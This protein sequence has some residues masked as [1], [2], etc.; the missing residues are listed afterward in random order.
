MIPFRPIHT[1]LS[2]QMKN[3]GRQIILY[4]LRHLS[5]LLKKNLKWILG[6]SEVLEFRTLYYH[7]HSFLYPLYR[8]TQFIQCVSYHHYNYVKYWTH[9]NRTQKVTFLEFYPNPYKK[10]PYP[11]LFSFNEGRITQL[12]V[13]SLVNPILCS[14][15]K[16]QVIFQPISSERRV[17]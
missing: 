1:V 8:S 14:G 16:Y 9:I 11:S 2:L 3:I 13:I 12:N 6:V 4:D 17:N 15:I 10:D 5:L 7:A